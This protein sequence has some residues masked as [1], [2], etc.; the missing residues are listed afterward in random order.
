MAEAPPVPAAGME[1][2][3]AELGALSAEQA[4]APVN[5]VEVSGGRAGVR[6]TRPPGLVLHLWVEPGAVSKGIWL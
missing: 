2:L 5:T 1:A 3:A 6:K 4:A